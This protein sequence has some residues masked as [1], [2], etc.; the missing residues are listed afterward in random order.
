[1]KKLFLLSLICFLLTNAAAAQTFANVRKINFANFT[2]KIAG[3]TVKMRDGLQTG[4]CPK[5]AD[6]VPSGD[7]WNVLP[8]N[9]AYGDLDGD[10]KEEA[11]I[12]MAANVCGGNMI[13][14]ETVLVYTIKNGKPAKMPEFEYFDEGCKDGEKGCDF[15][16]SPGVLVGYDAKLKALVVETFFA[17]ENDATCC[18]SL[19]RKTWYKWNGST[20]AEL[21]KSKIAVV[22]K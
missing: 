6:G 18:P 3:K 16:R 14:D 19:S 20:F 5:D 12:P 9:I 22:K 10:G 21:K 17:T 1:M 8:E 2:F 11:I 7:I 4:V 15:T 13:T